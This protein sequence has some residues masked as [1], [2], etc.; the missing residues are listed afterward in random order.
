LTEAPFDALTLALCGVPAVALCG[1]SAP[2]EFLTRG[3][4]G[5]RY[6]LAFDADEAGDKAAE[7]IGASLKRSGGLVERLRPSSAK[8]W[9]EA[10]QAGG[11]VWDRTEEALRALIA[12]EAKAC[13]VAGE[14]GIF[15]P[16]TQDRLASAWGAAHAPHKPLAGVVWH[17][18]KGV[19][20]EDIERW[21][22]LRDEQIKRLSEPS[23]QATAGGSGAPLW[24]ETKLGARIAA[25][26]CEFA[27][28]WA[29]GE[30]WARREADMMPRETQGAPVAGFS[31]N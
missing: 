15:H 31:G 9:N 19:R 6:W 27:L 23:Y 5:R 24:T 1:S 18:D 20:V 26:L 11:V 8:D 30:A 2:P 14:G 21:L 3:A 22:V 10:L 4:F 7:A 25:D 28:W 16:T 29:S 12:R 13:P 17:R